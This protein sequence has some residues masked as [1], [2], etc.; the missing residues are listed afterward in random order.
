MREY[1]ASMIIDIVSDVICPW[2]YI[3]K[4]R[5]ERAL[6]LA[7]QPDLQIGWRPFQLNPDMPPEGMDRE[8]YLQAKFGAAKGGRMYE[9]VSAAGAEEGIAFAFDRIRRTPNTIKP[10]RLIRWAGAQDCQDSIVEAL[11]QAYFTAGEDL[12]DDATLIRIAHGAGLPPEATAAYLASDED[13][14]QIRSEDAFAREVGINGVPCFIIDRKFALSG[15]QAPEAF[16]EV[17]ELAKREAE[18]PMPDAV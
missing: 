1:V 9:Q 5:L 16:L 15:A 10:H 17:F 13:E 3:G 12:T 8:A 6:A 11:F 7:P 14:A 2:C 18:A 4:R